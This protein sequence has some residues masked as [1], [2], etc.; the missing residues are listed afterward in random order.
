MSDTDRPS[1][2]PPAPVTR[3]VTDPELRVVPETAI[4]TAVRVAREAR[5][6]GRRALRLL[7]RAP[8]PTVERDEGQGVIGDVAMLKRRVGEAPDPIEKTPGYG[9][10]AGLLR[11]EDALAL[12]TTELRADREGREKMRAFF[13]KLAWG[14]GLPVAIAVVLG[15][16]AIAW[17]WASTLH[18]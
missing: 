10:A 6:L 11:V 13:T 7:G 17:S 1:S 8:D 12:L 16:G 3:A 18:H 15:F 4:E 5:E 14:L 9:M 2:G